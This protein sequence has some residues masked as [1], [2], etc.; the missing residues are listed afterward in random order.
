MLRRLVSTTCGVGGFIANN[1][2]KD[3]ACLN[4][5]EL[6]PWD[7]WGMITSPYHPPPKTHMAVL[8]EVAE[9]VTGDDFDAI[10]H[11]FEQDDRL[12]VPGD[13]VSFVD[14]KAKRVSLTDLFGADSSRTSRPTGY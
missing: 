11:R 2:V 3:F 6:L 10:R 13:I 4:K 14:G 5:V 1:V 9:L 8:D 12:R 7:S